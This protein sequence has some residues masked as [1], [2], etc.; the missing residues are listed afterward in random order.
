MAGT[1]KMG[2]DAM[3]VVD[4]ELRVYGCQ[5]LRVVDASIMPLVVSGNTNAPTIMIGEKA[6][7]MIKQSAAGA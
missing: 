1:C 4:P 6:A 5:G 2:V 3:A 7:D